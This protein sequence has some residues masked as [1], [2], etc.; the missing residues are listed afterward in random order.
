MANSPATNHKQAIAAARTRRE[1]SLF[2]CPH[3]RHVALATVRGF[4]Q[5]EQVVTRR[6][7]VPF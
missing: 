2:G 1:N 6:I 5:P 3:Q 7:H 4:P